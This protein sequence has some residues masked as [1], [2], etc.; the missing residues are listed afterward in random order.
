MTYKYVQAVPLAAIGAGSVT[1]YTVPTSASIVQV[2]SAKVHNP[3]AGVIV[4]ELHIV[5]PAGLSA[6]TNQVIKRS[7]AV[8]ETYMCPELLNTSLIPGNILIGSG[9]NLN[10]EMSVAEVVQ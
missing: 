9:E 6:T 7:I 8:N 2:R 4:F 10:F 5:V 1:L 3:T